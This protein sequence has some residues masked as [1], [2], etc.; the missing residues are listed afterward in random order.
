MMNFFDLD[1]CNVV[2]VLGIC[3]HI[4]LE[5]CEK[6]IEG[7]EFRTLADLLIRYGTTL[8]ENLRIFVIVDV[9]NSIQC[10]H[11]NDFVHGDLTY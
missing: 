4:V 8:P 1:H 10:L 6:V 3:L 11:D 9:A 5:Y 2:K 7:T